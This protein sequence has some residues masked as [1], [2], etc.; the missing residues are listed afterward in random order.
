MAATLRRLGRSEMSSAT[1]TTIAFGETDQFIHRFSADDIPPRLMELF[2]AS[3]PV[4]NAVAPDWAKAQVALAVN[5]ADLRAVADYAIAGSCADLDAV[6]I[7]V[8]DP[9]PGVLGPAIEVD[10][11]VAT[12]AAELSVKILGGPSVIV[13]ECPTKEYL[14]WLAAWT[15]YQ[16]ALT[17]WMASMPNPTSEPPTQPEE[18]DGDKFTDGR[19]KRRVFLVRWYIKITA[20]PLSYQDTA[21]QRHTVWTTC[22]EGD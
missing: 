19:R 15:E 13:Q 14:T 3:A 11:V 1:E 5:A 8:L 9:E 7:S 12:I 4:L 17:R 21:T 2:L 18:F 20:G 10:L 6:E 22:C 16:Y